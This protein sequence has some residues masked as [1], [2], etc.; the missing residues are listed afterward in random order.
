VYAWVVGPAYETPA[1]I[2]WLRTAGADL[3]GMSTV[4][5]AIVARQMGMEVLAV[6]CVANRAAGLEGRPLAHHDVLSVAHQAAPRLV[7]LL[8]GVIERL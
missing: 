5:E 3:V 6:S 8:Q 2:R 7:A 1:E 4:P